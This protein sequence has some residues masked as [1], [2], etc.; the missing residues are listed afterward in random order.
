MI[1]EMSLKNFKAFKNLDKLSFAPLTVL[2]GKNSSG[3]SSILQS[4]LLLKQTLSAEHSSSEEALILDGDY[5]HYSN[6]KEI[7]FGLP[8]EQSSMILYSFDLID[9]E[10]SDIGTICFEI[11][12]RE[13]LKPKRKA[14]V[15]TKFSWKTKDDKNIH[16]VNLYN[17]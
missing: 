6:I 4:L 12:N 1:K 9:E 5:L 14:P 2:S 7:V 10:H 17:T 16:T 15:V 11:R 13:L 8:R 3:K